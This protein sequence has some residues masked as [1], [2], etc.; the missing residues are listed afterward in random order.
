MTLSSGERWG[1]YEVLEPLGAGGMGEVYRARD[2]K[3]GRDV[4]LKVLPDELSRDP[5]RTARFERE[6]RLLASLNHPNVATLYGFED[7]A[8]AMELI[9]GETLAERLERGPMTLSEARD[10]FVQIAD[11]LEAAHDKGIVHRD[12]KPANVKL[13]PDGNVKILDFGIAKA[14]AP[15]GDASDESRT[16][17]KGTELG[18]VLGTASYMSPEQARGQAVD[19]RTDV[20][21]FGCCLFEALAG[22]KAFDGESVA[23][24]LGAVLRAEP[25]LSRL[26]EPPRTLVARCLAKDPRERLRDIGDARLEIREAREAVAS[27]VGTSEGRRRARGRCRDRRLDGLVRD[28]APEPVAG[29]R[30]PDLVAAAGGGVSG[31]RFEGAAHRIRQHGARALS[32]RVG[33]RLRCRLRGGHEPLSPLPFRIRLDADSGDGGSASSLLFPG[34]SLGRLLDRQ[35]GEEGPSRWERTVHPRRRA[36]AGPG[37]V[38]ERRPHLLCQQPRD[39]GVASSR[40]RWPRDDLDPGALY[41]RR[42]HASRR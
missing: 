6:A 13:T 28:A 31:A 17:T 34:R 25:E 40:I 42:R 23:D 16:R 41:H 24:V 26:S 11:G 27:T 7:G 35:S 8:L 3:L 15:E 32:R 30:S 10:V 39:G 19:K 33:A 38:G 9:E 4:A 5:E 22:R 36:Y 29:A 2:P 1:A 20:W 14:L 18:V 21:A 12:L 37:D